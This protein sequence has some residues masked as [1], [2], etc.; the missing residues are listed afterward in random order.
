VAE[1]AQLTATLVLNDQATAKLQAF[2]RQLTVT[3]QG[4][5]TVG[6]QGQA[7]SRQLST[8]FADVAHNLGAVDV[9]ALATKASLAGLAAAGVAGLV[10]MGKAAADFEQAMANVRSVLDPAEIAQFGPAL[11]KLALQLGQTTTFS[12]KEAAAGLES[13]AKAGLSVSDI[14]GGAG[15]ASLDLA[16]AGGLKVGEAADIAANALQLFALNGDDARHVADLFAGTANATTADVHDLGLGM[17][18]FGAVAKLT[19]QDVDS[20]TTAIGLMAQAGIKGSDAGTS[21]KTM[22]LNLQ[23]QTKSAADEMQRLGLLTADGTNAFVNE[24]GAIKSTRDI[25]ETLQRATEGMTQA[26]RTLAL[27]TIF[28][29][30]AIRAA[31]TLATAGAEGYDKLKTSIDGVT[32]AQ[33]AAARTDTLEGSLKRLQ[34]AWEALQITLVGATGGPA[35]AGVDA[36]T[37][38]VQG[39]TAAVEQ[40]GG[41]AAV[42]FP[43]IGRLAG[44]AA[45]NIQASFG[46]SWV[47]AIAAGLGALPPAAEA[48]GIDL[49]KALAGGLQLGLKVSPLG[50]AV[51]AAFGLKDVGTALEVQAAAAAEEALGPQ[52]RVYRDITYYA[53]DLVGRYVLEWKAAVEKDGAV[54]LQAGGNEALQAFIQ[55]LRDRFPQLEATMPEVFDA[56]VRDVQGQAT[57]L[58]GA[59]KT[60]GTALAQGVQEGIDPIFHAAA[61]TLDQLAAVAREKATVIRDVLAT[62]ID[63]ADISRALEYQDAIKQVDA[64]I[65]QITDVSIRAYLIALRNSNDVEQAAAEAARY[66]AAQ[67]ASQATATDKATSSTRAEAAAQRDLAA[68]EAAAAA[69]AAPAVAG[70]SKGGIYTPQ[71]PPAGA[72]VGGMGAG[73]LTPS[74]G[75][76]PTPLTSPTDAELGDFGWRGRQLF[77]D[78]GSWQYEQWRRYMASWGAQPGQLGPYVSPGTFFGGRSGGGFGALTGGGRGGGPTL[79]GLGGGGAPGPSD[80]QTFRDAAGAVQQYATA[81]LA[82]TAAER[83]HAAATQVLQTNI[84]AVYAAY[85]AS[86]QAAAV[87]SGTT[88]SPSGQVNQGGGNYWQNMLAQSANDFN[89]Q[90]LN[91]QRQ[92]A[93]GNLADNVTVVIQPPP[94]TMLPSTSVDKA[95]WATAMAPY[96]KTALQELG[97]L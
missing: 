66:L 31:A 48:A 83:A 1:V 8:G 15:R 7:A 9:A 57:Q 77:P 49:G 20:A 21:L 50:P 17:A 53:Q 28:G 88:T 2:Q 85:T 11:D 58:Y 29:T 25:A 23:P 93:Q 92:W 46:P 55:G 3:G 60:V 6:Q 34:G 95:S 87:G 84:P 30:D 86:V 4:L 14:L 36:L 61:L 42:V 65:S 18:Q 71:A 51:I 12:A 70:F 47:G 32:A 78:T 44:L 41:H 37:A 63:P 16:A 5:T 22:F 13:L 56:I 40:L 19:G 89:A 67:K 35:R 94:Q 10:S 39:T 64:A 68:A 27:Q 91:Q 81:V 33:V 73:F 24:A 52:A 45:A 62:S 43:E 38:A 75:A 96:V 76:G 80:V 82:A 72:G 54:E 79:L 59:G 74:Y 97:V 90:A 26:Q 69:A